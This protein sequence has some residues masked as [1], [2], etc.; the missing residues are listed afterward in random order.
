MVFGRKNTATLSERRQKDRE[1]VAIGAVV[2]R[3]EDEPVAIDVEIISG[4]GFLARTPLLLPMGMV[5]RVCFPSGRAPHARVV[6]LEDSKVG[7]EFLT[8]VD[9]ND[10]LIVPAPRHRASDRQFARKFRL[11]L[12]RSIGRPH[13]SGD[14][15]DLFSGA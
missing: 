12:T 8:S 6:W 3:P 4:R 5:V 9:V 2:H 13:E 7:C 14:Q 11:P 15:Y 1:R 10:L